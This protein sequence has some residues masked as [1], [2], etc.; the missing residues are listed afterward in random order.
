VNADAEAMAVAAP[1]PAIGV[2]GIVFDAQGRVLLIQRATP[3]QQGLWHVPGG[4]L[5]PGESLVEACR[6]EVLEETGVQIEVQRL[7]ALV[8][9]RE[10]GFH[11][12]IVD[13]LGT[14]VAGSD[15]DCRPADD[16]ANAAWVAPDELATYPLAPGL[17]P[18]LERARR[19][20]S[21]EDLG[22]VARELP[23]TDFLPKP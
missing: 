7:L 19:A 18:I 12:V 14:L 4:K 13:F 1:K 22:L 17:A 16:A 11:Y 8:E 15:A 21:G 23:M 3:P 10:Q 2:A 5:E 9:R 20:L 6:R